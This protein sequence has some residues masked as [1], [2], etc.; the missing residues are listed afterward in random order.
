MKSWRDAF[1]NYLNPKVFIFLFLGFSCGLPYN[2]LGYSLS[3]WMREVNISLAVIGFFSFVFLPY[4]FKFLWA[5]F[6]D[7]I[8]IP[9]L[10]KIGQKKAWALVFQACLVCCILGLALYPSNANTWTLSIEIKN[11][12]LQIPMQTFLFAILTAFFAASQDI[13]VD[14]LRIDTLSKDELG[15][16]AGT[17]QLGYRLAL[18]VSGA[19]VVMISSLISWRL[20]Y[21]IVGLFCLSGLFAIL[22]VKE[23]PQESVQN[24]QLFKQM[25]I[26]PF[27][28]FM[29]RKDWLLILVFIVLYK[30]CNAVLGR[31]AVP[32]YNDIGFTKNQIGLI[33]GTFGPWVTI[34]GVFLGGVLVARFSVLKC[35]LGLGFVEILTSCAFAFLAYLGNNP[36]I[37]TATIFFD[38]VVGGM[39]GTVFIAFL[40]GLCSKKY[41]ATQ[42]ALLS[43]LMA[44]SASVISAQSGVWAEEMG[45]VNFFLYTGVLMVPALILLVFIMRGQDESRTLS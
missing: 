17:Y 29:Q 9:V 45:Y 43:S 19:G 22:F 44:V 18:F 10:W 6:V 14:S 39:G 15:E 3:L 26:E 25:V 32:F 20:A 27:Y 41:S 1:L 24:Q 12:V 40:S 36:I 21:A 30:L 28:D 38:N 34:V 4:S 2:L 31:M 37:F 35:L 23:A 11:E 7:K 33:S 8:R 5:P 13:V 16:A 42:Y